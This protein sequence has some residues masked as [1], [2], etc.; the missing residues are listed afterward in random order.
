MQTCGIPSITLLGTRED[1]ANLRAKL[2]RLPD[3]GSEPAKFATRLR[4]ILNRFVLSFD[5]PRSEEVTSFWN[6]IVKGDPS[7]GSGMPPYK[8]SGWLMGFFYWDSKGKP[9]FDNHYARPPCEMELDGQC[10]L[11]VHVP[12]IPIGCARAPIKLLNHAE[13]PENGGEYSAI[14]VAGALGKKITAGVPE[15]LGNLLANDTIDGHDNSSNRVV[16][17]ES[18]LNLST[19]QS[20]P[21]AKQGTLQPISGWFLFGPDKE[22]RPTFCHSENEDLYRL[23]R[24]DEEW[25]QEHKCKAAAGRDRVSSLQI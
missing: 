4:P 3:F 7:S 1:W 12:D 25:R 16:D 23:F 19:L 5:A 22:K 14:V 18:G 11:S 15:H 24:K 10:Y 9:K 13:H 20:V 2:D 21:L 17:Q 8:V 6:R